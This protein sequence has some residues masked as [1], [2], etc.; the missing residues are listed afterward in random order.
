M[1][2]GLVSPLLFEY[3]LVPLSVKSVDQRNSWCIKTGHGD[4]FFKK[5]EVGHQQIVDT[6]QKFLVLQKSGF[7]G[8]IPYV[9]TKYGE[10]FIVAGKDNYALFPWVE[11][12][13]DIHELKKWEVKV[14]KQLALLHKLSEIKSGSGTIPEEILNGVKNKWENRVEEFKSFRLKNHT[15]INSLIEEGRKKALRLS[16]LAINRLDEINQ[17]THLEGTI[18]RAIC[19]GRINRKNI[20][21]GKNKKIYFIN[22]EKAT[23]D[24][25]VKDLALFLRRYAPYIHWDPVVGHEWL[26]GY[27]QG[28]PLTHGEKLLLG[29]YL[30]FPERV[31]GEVLQNG[32]SS[33]F[34]QK[35]FY[36]WQ[37]RVE[38]LGAIERFVKTITSI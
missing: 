35:G 13:C 33:L 29:C 26:R 15:R 8:M 1:E 24:T 32:K 28:F 30:L 5:L 20:I 27:N 10:D 3:D 9:K 25:H 16:H 23:M 21:V 31:I 36:Q 17:S 18:R 2:H 6:V 7:P 14:L 11:K 37:K 4:F 38:E 19:H 34:Q 12:T 22:F